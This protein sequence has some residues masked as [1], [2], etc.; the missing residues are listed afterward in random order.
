MADD[1]SH[2]VTRFVR[3]VA[4]RR[5]AWRTL[6][7]V[8]VAA[9]VFGAGIAFG[10]WPPAVIASLG[11]L[12]LGT[13]ILEKP[14]VTAEYMDRKGGHLGLIECAIDHIES[15]EPII[16]A[17]RG[18]AWKILSDSAPH[19]YAPS[20]SAVWW[21]P[22]IGVI[23]ISVVVAGE[24][25]VREQDSD[26]STPAK[27]ATSQEQGHSEPGGVKPSKKNP[28]VDTVA[29]P[30]LTQRAQ[31][32]N[33]SAENAMM[34]AE[35]QAGRKV[36]TSKGGQLGEKRTAIEHAKNASKI[37]LKGS[38][39]NVIRGGIIQSTVGEPA[40]PYPEKYHEVIESWFK[41]RKQ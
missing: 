16:V 14:R 4:A 5:A 25:S 32:S 9:V 29:Q 23:V 10:V 34:E 3:R 18:R 12:A 28:R 39:Q 30:F 36:G 41:R 7:Q 15:R 19:L 24:R 20:P 17:Q 6:R 31:E 38:R 22:V 40:R 33:Q 2:R 26:H 1:I 35:G 21:L 37:H 11:L 8:T 13:L 27:V